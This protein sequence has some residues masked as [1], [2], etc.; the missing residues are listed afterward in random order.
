MTRSLCLKGLDVQAHAMNKVRNR[1]HCA[2]LGGGGL[3]V[4]EEMVAAPVA[5]QA[6][7][8]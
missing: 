6:S 2:T 5:T 3:T 4:V 7:S 8:V 1:L